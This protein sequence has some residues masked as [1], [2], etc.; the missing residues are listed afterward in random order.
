MVSSLVRKKSKIKI[1]SERFCQAES[2][3]AVD[4]G[5]FLP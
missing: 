4:L 3:A 5:L 2:L 1:L